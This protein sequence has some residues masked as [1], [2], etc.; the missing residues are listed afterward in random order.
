MVIIIGFIISLL[1]YAKQEKHTT[2]LMLSLRQADLYLMATAIE[3]ANVSRIYRTGK[4]E[5]EAL[6]GI[7]LQIAGG[8]MTAIMGPSG[9]GKTTLMN[10]V[11]LLERPTGG[12][13]KIGGS[14]VEM[15]MSDK[16]L[17]ELRLEKIG[18][19]FQS[20]QLLPRM[21]A[22]ANV[23]LPTAYRKNGKVGRERRAYEILARLGL[24]ERAHHK[25][26]EL[27]GGEKQRVAIA[28][29]LINDPE[30][31]L[32][33]EPTGN[34]DSTSGAEV[35]RV[36]KDLRAQGK[37]V[38]IIT[39][40]QNV[41]RHCDRTVTLFDGLIVHGLEP[42]ETASTNNERDFDKCLIT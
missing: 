20:F 14:L 39:H 18:F 30:I 33:D 27:S 26:T 41:A 9:A 6:R 7:D 25:P 10:I 17:A 4:V 22:F 38:V 42:A 11:G 36:L 8:E 19:V 5:V 13:L 21:T 3:L 28:R 24:K 23:L 32:A 16:A 12:L 31:I 34:L 2:F 29:A 35:L 1:Y 15:S 37:T 40:D